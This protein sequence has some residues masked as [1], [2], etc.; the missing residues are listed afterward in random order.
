LFEASSPASLPKIRREVCWFIDGKP[1]LNTIY[2]K[3]QF[4]NTREC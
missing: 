1:D 4:D 2:D 3:E